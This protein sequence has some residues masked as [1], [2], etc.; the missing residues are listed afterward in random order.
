MQPFI[1]LMPELALFSIFFAYFINGTDLGSSI[2]MLIIRLI[3]IK[4]IH[5]ILACPYCLSFHIYFSSSCVVM[6][7]K[8]DTSAFYVFSNLT[9]ALVIAYVSRLVLKY[10]M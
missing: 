5:Y 6:I 1:N 3:N 8:G 4:T 2:A 10:G 7:A 9:Y